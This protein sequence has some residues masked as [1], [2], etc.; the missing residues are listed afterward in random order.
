MLSD[1]LG[2]RRHGDRRRRLD[3]A[4]RG[5]PSGRG[6][7]RPDAAVP[8]VAVLQVALHVRGAAEYFVAHRALGCALVHIH[9]FIHRVP[10]PK[11]FTA[12]FAR[13]RRMFD[14]HRV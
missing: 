4:C 7:R 8:A 10:I 1:R 11:R 12:E 2:G 9:V 14:D 13:V 6:R 5:H 3:A